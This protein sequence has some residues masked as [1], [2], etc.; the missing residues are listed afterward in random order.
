M[1]R[2]DGV[3]VES[4]YLINYGLNGYLE[5]EDMELEDFAEHGFE[6][7]IFSVVFF[8]YNGYDF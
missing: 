2:D 3:V 8:P 6:T 5:P 4:F 1:E 7:N